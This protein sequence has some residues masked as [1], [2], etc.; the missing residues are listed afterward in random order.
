M[1]FHPSLYFIHQTNKFLVLFFW[2]W[3]VQLIIWK[4][5]PCL[6]NFCNVCISIICFSVYMYPCNTV[7]VFHH[8]LGL[9]NHTKTHTLQFY[10]V[11]LFAVPNRLVYSWEFEVFLISIINKQSVKNFVVWYLRY[12]TKYFFSFFC[13]Y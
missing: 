10:L 7:F 9:H 8:I 4:F 3:S 11:L 1:I 5:K 2:L 12:D 6:N 13:C